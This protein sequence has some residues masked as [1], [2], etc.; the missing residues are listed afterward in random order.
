MVYFNRKTLE[1]LGL[2]LMD[3]EKGNTTTGESGNYS[4]DGSGLPNHSTSES[5]SD[6]TVPASRQSGGEAVACVCMKTSYRPKLHLGWVQCDV[7]DR[8]CHITCAGAFACLSL[9]CTY[10]ATET[11]QLKSP[12]SST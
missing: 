5:R 12:V 3:K 10:D 6:K 4:G 2:I 9:L 1:V 7:C 11:R 8:Y